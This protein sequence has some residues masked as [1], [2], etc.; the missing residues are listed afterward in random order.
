VNRVGIHALV[1]VEGWTEPEIRLAL[2]RTKESGYDLIEIPLLD[3][4]EVGPELTARLLAEYQLEA[5][6]SLGLPFEA[7]VSSEDEEVRARGE[8]LLRDAV[9]VTAAAGAGFLGGVVHSA[10]GKYLAPPTARGRANCV[11]TLARVAE[12]ARREDVTI[13]IEAVNR[14][15]S[16]V[17]NTAEQALALLDDIG[18]ANVVVHLDSYHMNIEETDA[19][20]AVRRA[21]TR[22][23]YVHVGESHRGELGTGSVDFAALFGALAEIG[24]DGPVTFESFSSVVV[25]EQFQT[26]LA[27]WRRPWDDGLDVARRARAFIADQLNA[28]TNA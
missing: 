11:A 24:Y 14:Y 18:A 26:A 6:C 16:N 25:S 27:V 22:L 23:G 21:G 15:E 3:P 1:W 5:S 7:D 8:R 9:R 10:M 20:E 2:E 28:A 4:S 17:V 19:A 12:E 13:G